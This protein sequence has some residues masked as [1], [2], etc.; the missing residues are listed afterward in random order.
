M[1]KLGVIN[2]AFLL[3]A[4]CV[5]QVA[6]RSV[7]G[8]ARTSGG[9]FP[10]ER[11]CTACH[12]GSEVN[13]G[14]GTLSLTVGGVATSAESPP[15]Y[16]PGETIALIVSFEDT[17]K[18]RVGF[19]LTARSGDG[20][21]Q[22]GSLAAA[23]SADGSGIKT[24]SGSCGPAGTQVQWVTHQTPRNGSSATFAIDWTAPAEDVG[25]V[26]IAL[27]VNGADGARNAR[28]DNIY[29][30]Q[31]VLQPS[32]AAS[33]I[34]PVISENGVTS[35][36]DSETALTTGAPGGIAV[37]S[38]TGFAEMGEGTLGSIGADGA[39]A[40]NTGGVCVEVNQVRAPVLY[41]DATAV[42]VQ[43]PAETGL[44]PAAVQVIGNCD[45]DAD[46][47]QAVLSNT[48]M[49]EIASVKPTLVH[50][51][52]STSGAVA[53]HADFSLVAS[54]PETPADTEMSAMPE[55]PGDDA[56]D[57][58][59][60]MSPAVPGE[61]VTLFGTG[62]GPTDPAL[63][64]G[65]IPILSHVLTAESVQLM[66]GETTI[67]DDHIVYAGATPGV[68]GL[69]QL[70]AR[71]PDAMPAGEFAVSLMVDMQASPAGATI[72]I[73]MPE[74][75]DD[76][77][78]C[79]AGLVLKVGESC[80]GSVS[81]GETVYTGVFEVQETQACVNVAGISLPC[82]TETLNPLGLGLLIAEK[83]SDGT[84]KIIKFG[85]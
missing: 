38:G 78:T 44:G 9:A 13:S 39:L 16:T 41:A 70:S 47:G 31:A 2:L 5:P 75:D 82:G 8:P 66:L 79:V 77:V 85:D 27:A 49:F 28:D 17:T 40:T 37:I 83:Q 23:S 18:F 64:S 4:V 7:G 80:S 52:E 76:G 84:W 12:V 72:A 14:P 10:G 58:G 63:A 36:G 6:A 67:P 3:A 32:A 68:A 50:V 60:E 29:T 51:S 20:C 43:V 42:Y 53:V 21:G 48:V 65:E 56:G 62:F 24:E 34:S 61:V 46:G 81:L 59:P 1:G 33:P 19:Q 35:L 15:T 71:I 11:D 55:P 57:A 73:G 45:P 69:Y 74:S 30:L 54:E 25:P 22:P 26:T